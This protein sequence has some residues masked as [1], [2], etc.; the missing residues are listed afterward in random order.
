MPN[1]L[2]QFGAT[3]DLEVILDDLILKEAHLGKTL[4][5][6]GSVKKNVTVPLGLSVGFTCRFIV[7]GTGDLGIL[8]GDRVTI[9]AKFGGN[10]SITEQYT[11]SV[12]TQYDKNIYQMSNFGLAN[13]DL[14]AAL[15]LK[16][17]VGY[18][19]VLSQ[20]GTA[21]PTA[22]NATNNL[23]GAVTL[24]RLDVGAYTIV[25]TG[26][27]LTGTFVIL[28]LQGGSTTNAVFA[29]WQRVDDNTIAI[30]I[31]DIDGNG[32]E[33]STGAQQISVII[34]TA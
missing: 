32:I 1:Y 8:S 15:A 10:A 5:Y 31:F 33:L 26:A 29:L 14:V 6:F 23:S 16:Q 34:V 13:V 22:A 20:T 24:G 2:D 4:V 17:K 9:N 11:D 28:S 30:N 21:A 18:S 25:R 7:A 12:L 27:F 3:A 19:A